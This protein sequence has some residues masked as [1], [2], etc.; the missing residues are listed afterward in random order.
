MRDVPPP[1]VREVPPPPPAPAVAKDDAKHEEDEEDGG[2][3]WVLVAPAP[4]PLES[5]REMCAGC[6][7]VEP[8][9]G[10]PAD[11]A[12]TMALVEF[13]AERDA[14][15]AVAA[16]A[17]LGHEAEIARRTLWQDDE[18]DADVTSTI[19]R[20]E[21]VSATIHE[22][23]VASVFG[24]YGTCIAATREEGT[25]AF[26]VR[27]ADRRGA[28]TATAALSGVYRF[29]EGQEFPVRVTWCPCPSKKSG[30]DRSSAAGEKR[31]RDEDVANGEGATLSAKQ[32][33]AVGLPATTQSGEQ[34]AGW[35]A[36]EGGACLLFDKDRRCAI[37]AFPTADA[38]TEALDTH[39]GTLRPEGNP[40]PVTLRRI[41]C[42]VA[43]R[44]K[45]RVAVQGPPPGVW[46]PVPKPGP[47][48]GEPSAKI[49]IGSIP[50]EYAEDDVRRIFS[51]V[52]EVR[53]VKILRNPGDGRHK[54]S[55]FVTF[56][57]IAATE[58]AIHFIDNKYTLIAPA[59]PLQKPIYMKYAKIGRT[60]A[61]PQQPMVYQQPMAYQQPYYPPQQAY[62]H[63]PQHPQQAYAQYP[64]QAYGQYPQQG[65]APQGPTHQ[66]QQMWQ[67]GFGGGAQQ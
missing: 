51:T 62:G 57:D 54:G 39:G 6:V 40:C 43:L 28:E 59:H 67:Q 49:Y 7:S 38:A 25:D 33:L 11:G 60:S 10:G 13:A 12:S 24:T 44:P 36:A 20:V 2:E 55:G 21:G 46:P 35:F 4:T 50:Q 34:V 64:Q 52:G 63:Y 14:L 66:Q 48:Y 53:E 26:A 29:E 30:G 37:L 16:L 45:K 65:Q 23:I 9:G 27:M 18:D 1:P 3:K 61:A 31:K 5:L 56:S 17:A 15:N 8:L 41:A 22:S 32:L 19:V 47:E 58:R 42:D